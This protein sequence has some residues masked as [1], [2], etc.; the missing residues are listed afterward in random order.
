MQNK[1]PDYFNESVRFIS[2]LHNRNDIEPI[3]DFFMTHFEKDS[4]IRSLTNFGIREDKKEE[5]QNMY[6]NKRQS[7]RKST[8]C[9]A[10]ETKYFLETPNGYRLTK[11]LYHASGNIF[12]NHKQLLLS[13]LNNNVIST[14]TCTPF[15]KKLFVTVTGKILPCEIVDHDFVFGFVQDDYVELD[16][17]HV[18]NRFNYY[19]SKCAK[20]CICCETNTYCR[21]CIFQIDSIRCES[22]HCL[23]FCTKE[24]YQK[25]KEQIFDCLRQHPHYYEKVLNEVSFT[26]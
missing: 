2:V 14:G 7:L 11:Y 10:I 6:Q 18:A 19:L 13:E 1:Y 5:F 20:Q 22:P 21:Q 26:L 16:C 23:S 3:Y 9:E 4:M 17:Q 12:F 8:N 15:S 24:A 25:D